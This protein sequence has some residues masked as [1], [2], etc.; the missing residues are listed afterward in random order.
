MYGSVF[1]ASSGYRGMPLGL[2]A[3]PEW[4]RSS[5]TK[6]AAVF[7]AAVVAAALDAVRPKQVWQVADVGAPTPSTRLGSSFSRRQDD[8]HQLEHVEPSDEG[9]RDL[10]AERRQHVTSRRNTS[11]PSP[12]LLQTM[13]VPGR[14]ETPGLR[15]PDE[16]VVH[17]YMQ[18]G[19][20]RCCAKNKKRLDQRAQGTPASIAV[21]SDYR[22][23]PASSRSNGTLD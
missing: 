7:D 3:N 19:R 8:L 17:S 10:F 5:V 20:R 18:L 23:H 6:T 21:D 9:K 14:T 2:A 4:S 16:D 11:H 22:A 12:W 1:W 13:P 15:A